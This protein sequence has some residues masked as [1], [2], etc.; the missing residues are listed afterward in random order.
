MWQRS[1][2]KTDFIFGCADDMRAAFMA[3]S[4]R[5]SFAAMPCY[6]STSVAGGCAGGVGG[7]GV[8]NSSGIRP[9][10]SC[11]GTGDSGSCIGGGTSGPGCVAAPPDGPV[12]RAALPSVHHPSRVSIPTLTGLCSNL[13]SLFP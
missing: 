9:G 5:A 6:V 3:H 8:G 13:R 4:D 10:N 7:L 12:C 2:A 11:G 1:A